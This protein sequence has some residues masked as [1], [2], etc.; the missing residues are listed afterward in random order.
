MLQA[1]VPAPLPDPP[2]SWTPSGRTGWPPVFKFATT[3][4]LG[5]PVLCST[6]RQCTGA[7]P[8]GRD[9]GTS[10][11]DGLGRLTSASA[12]TV[13]PP[14]A[15]SQTF[16]KQELWRRCCSSTGCSQSQCEHE[17]A[18]AHGS[19]WPLSSRPAGAER[20]LEVFG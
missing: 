3:T 10:A 17:E 13:R 8:A 9:A 14:E 15:Q 4:V 7:T 5:P 19:R 16:C 2:R 18:A 6:E 11:R 12:A 1:A 20:G